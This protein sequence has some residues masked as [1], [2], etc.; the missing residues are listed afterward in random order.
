M[1][2]A[3]VS[4]YDVWSAHHNQAG[5]GFVRTISAGVNYENRFMVKEISTRGGALAIPVKAGTFGLVYH[6][7]W[8]PTYTAKTNTACHL[9]KHLAINFRQ[10]LRWII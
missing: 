4:L 5:L 2:N 6:Q 8:L 9:Q 1:G 7:L 3:S 10:E